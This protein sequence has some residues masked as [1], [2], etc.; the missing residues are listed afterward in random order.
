MNSSAKLMDVTPCQKELR[1]EVPLEVVQAEFE[2]V[3][4]D[5]K[6]SARVP[7]F[8]VGYA[9]RD[10]LEHYHGNKAREEVLKRL[11]N[12]SLEEALRSQGSLDLVGRPE[13]TEVKFESQQPLTY[14]AKLEV[15]PEVPLGRYRGL[16]LT[17][18]KVQVSQEMVT[19]VLAR[20]QDQQ[21]ELKPVLEPRAAAA[22]DFL[23]VDLTEVPKG[24]PVA[25]RRDIVIPL[26]L[27]KDPEGILKEFVGM[28]PGNQR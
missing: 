12:R 8:R 20:L 11:I 15:A 18:P 26:E 24:K 7:G 10:L 19:Q 27:E 17:R 1:V 2:A 13:I 25:K 14:L 16:K 4:R 28:V 3:Y 6:K 21:S 9:P 23:L 5:L 22:G